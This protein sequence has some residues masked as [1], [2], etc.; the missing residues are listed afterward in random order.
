MNSKEIFSNRVD[1]YVKYRPSYPGE[2]ID[3]LYNTIGLQPNCDIADIGAGTG[4]FSALLLERGSRVTAVEPNP[5]M[6][7]AAEENFAKD[8][9]F[10]VSPG[11]AEHTELSDQSMDF[12][13]C[14]QAFH[15]FDRDATQLEFKR[16]LKPGGK[17]ILIWNSRLTYGTPF[18]EEYEQLLQTF[19]TNYTQVNHKNITPEILSSFFK[20]GQMQVA[21]FSNQQVF[22]L[23]GLSGRL[24]SSSYTPVP[25][26]PSYENM[27]AELRNIF[28]RN[29]QGGQVFFDYNTEIY[30]GEV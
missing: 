19:G 14:A 11:S 24:R 2:A 8:N 28:E 18:L 9:H 25:G 29:N 30:W 3:Y 10:S 17:V 5:E 23:E 22:D 4:I 13:V 21:H 6:R 1:S 27:M 12:I 16:I 15:W 26:D 7:R 20:K